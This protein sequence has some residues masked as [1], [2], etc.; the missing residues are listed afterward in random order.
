MHGTS[1]PSKLLNLSNVGEYVLNRGGLGAA[2][3]YALGMTDRYC[4]SVS[5]SEPAPSPSLNTLEKSIE[6]RK[7]FI[8]DELKCATS[9]FGLPLRTFAAY[10]TG[11]PSQSHIRTSNTPRART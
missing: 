7:P 9:S 6:A 4:P 11:E 5:G 3:R 1:S 2:W 8:R 10:A